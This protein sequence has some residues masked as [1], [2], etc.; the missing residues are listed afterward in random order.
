MSAMIWSI[1]FIREKVEKTNIMFLG[2]ISL[3]LF[4]TEPNFIGDISW[5]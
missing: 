5:L 1:L 3:H 2:M 4:Y